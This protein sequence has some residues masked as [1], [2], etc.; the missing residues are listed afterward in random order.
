MESQYRVTYEVE[1]IRGICPV[2]KVGDKIV[3]DSK[4]PV[5][6]INLDKTDAVCSR[7]L[8]S[9]WT[10]HIWH[11]ADNPTIKYLTGVAGECRV[12]CPM[13]GKPYTPCG[14]TVFIIKRERIPRR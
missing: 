10:R 9:M 7:V 6:I 13:P 2:Y 14:N 5:E 11:S 3:F 12:A 1:E 4:Y 8:D